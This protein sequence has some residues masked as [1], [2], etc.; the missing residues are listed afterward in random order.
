[1]GLFDNWPYVN[2]HE[3]NLDYVV[4]V[5]NEAKDRLDGYDEDVAEIAASKVAAEN[6]ATAAANSKNAA[7]SSA[8]SANSSKL[9]AASS[10]NNAHNSELAAAASESAAGTSADQAEAW[11]VGEID[12][13]PVDSSAAQ[14]HNN[15]KYYS[16]QA[17][18]L[19]VSSYAPY[20]I[21]AC[22]EFALN[23]LTVKKDRTVTKLDGTTVTL[24]VAGLV[25]FPAPYP[26]RPYDSEVYN[27]ENVHADKQSFT[28][29]AL[30]DTTDGY[31]NTIFIPYKGPEAYKIVDGK[32]YRLL[33]ARAFNALTG[34]MFADNAS[35]DHLRGIATNGIYSHAVPSG[36]NGAN[37]G[38]AEQ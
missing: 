19:A 26:Q 11:A 34:A 1:M 5:A 20:G 9:A 4:K 12:G 32:S 37:I 7:A 8:S 27:T 15:A 25:V 3:I 17:Q 36:E 21:G 23:N 18:P 6:A 2:F 14:Y 22:W 38:N 31:G 33:Y 30:W 35:F 28:L 29:V 13:V 10:E 16:D 24:D